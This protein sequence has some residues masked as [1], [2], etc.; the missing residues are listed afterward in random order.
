MSLFLNLA[1]SRTTVAHKHLY[2]V[3][4]HAN[5]DKNEFVFVQYVSW[6]KTQF[7]AVPFKTC[8][9]KSICVV[10]KNFVSI[11]ARHIQTH[12]KKIHATETF[13]YDA[14]W[15]FVSLNFFDTNCMQCGYTEWKSAACWKLSRKKI[16]SDS[17][18]SNLHR[19]PKTLLYKK[20]RMAGV[21]SSER[22]SP[23]QS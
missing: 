1:P 10:T 14:I 20:K 5:F 16:D 19:Q 4:K 21:I 23:V 13:R 22:G 9:T 3:P 8:Q 2:Q 18:L 6:E 17:K 7:G 11:C 15:I 12:R